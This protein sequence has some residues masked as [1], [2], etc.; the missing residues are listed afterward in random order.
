MS[1]ELAECF[2]IE[3]KRYMLEDKSQYLL[4]VI[5]E[6]AKLILENTDFDF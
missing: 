5:R 6:A 3:Y 1:V 4:V 2:M